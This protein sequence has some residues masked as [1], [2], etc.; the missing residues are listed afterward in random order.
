[1][2]EEDAARRDAKA[3]MAAR[4]EAMRIK[5]AADA[6]A[7]STAPDGIE[8]QPN[9]PVAQPEPPA[10]SGDVDPAAL[11]AME[12]QLQQAR[13][14]QRGAERE[15]TSL[16]DLMALQAEGIGTMQDELG[17]LHQQL[18]AARAENRST[19]AN[20]RLPVADAQQLRSLRRRARTLAAEL[21]TSKHLMQQL[22]AETEAGLGTAAAGVARLKLEAARG[23]QKLESLELA[24]ESLR[25]QL[26]SERVERQKAQAAAAAAEQRAAAADE[27]VARETQQLRDE[28]EEAVAERDALEQ[29]SKTRNAR[30][31][32]VQTAHTE[33]LEA[34]EA[35]LS[36]AQLAGSQANQKLEHEVGRL[37][38]HV[39]ALEATLQDSEASAAE[40]AEAAAESLADASAAKLAEQEMRESLSA[41]R[42]E[43]RQATIR[44]Q[45]AEVRLTSTSSLATH[46]LIQI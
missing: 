1:M 15:A 31:A 35:A 29:A 19:D 3:R 42:E 22:K 5:R 25:E 36:S 32:K 9:P 41:A 16:K 20:A 23:A 37:T 4:K 44:A 21:G 26:T 46:F 17:K 18:A 39:S 43:A 38:R 7:Q 45:E 8:T 12:Q 27:R 11:R 14:A 6:A 34:L 33:K 30:F 24:S 28:A 13:E 40:A 10:A 2:E